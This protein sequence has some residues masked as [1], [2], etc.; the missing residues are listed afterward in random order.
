MKKLKVGDCEEK[1]VSELN[2]ELYKKAK[3]ILGNDRHQHI[4]WSGVGQFID[5]LESEYEIKK[6]NVRR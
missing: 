4:G 5:W 6:K 2:N 1:E 3:Y